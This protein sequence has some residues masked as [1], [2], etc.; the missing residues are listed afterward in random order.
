VIDNIPDL[1]TEKTGAQ[2]PEDVDRN[3]IEQTPDVSRQVEAPTTV[4]SNTSPSHIQRQIQESPFQESITQSPVI[5]RLP[6]DDVIDSTVTQSL[7]L[8]PQQVDNVM[9]DTG[10]QQ[11]AVPLQNV[12]QVEKLA[13]QPQT[14]STPPQTLTTLQKS[15]N[16]AVNR[17]NR[18][19]SRMLDNIAAGGPTASSIEMVTPRFPRPVPLKTAEPTQQTT[20]MR[21]PTDSQV[22]SRSETSVTP[23]DTSESE[24]VVDTAIGPLPADLWTLIDEPVPISR[25]TQSERAE[26]PQ[27]LTARSDPGV[28]SNRIQRSERETTPSTAPGRT[29][30]HTQIEEKQQLVPSSTSQSVLASSSTEIASTAQVPSH[31]Q[32]VAQQR[33]TATQ[34]SAVQQRSSADI[35]E[36]AAAQEQTETLQEG[37][38]DGVDID[39]LAR[40]VYAEI[41]RKLTIEWERLRTKF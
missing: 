12:W 3:Q 23:V 33:R 14:S 38:S 39:D 30:L 19:I 21:K 5:E 20:I 27:A 29:R 26:N 37:E 2:L 13:P 22:H 4:D 28:Q 32:R 31:I 15:E 6:T 17:V 10:Q 35:G 36:T 25:Q 8:G 41:K 7:T 24:A 34:T 1:D 11:P 16:T 40:I 18:N 9:D